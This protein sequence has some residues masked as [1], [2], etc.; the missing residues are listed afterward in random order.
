MGQ[1]L[2][3]AAA[4]TVSSNLGEVPAWAGF[5]MAAEVLDRV[6]QGHA[7]GDLYAVL[8]VLPAIGGEE[9]A[10]ADRM[11]SFLVVKGLAVPVTKSLQVLF[12]MI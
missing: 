5:N 4:R 8:G 10:P 11:R 1:M 2:Q 12:S 6:L 7:R 9:C 3:I